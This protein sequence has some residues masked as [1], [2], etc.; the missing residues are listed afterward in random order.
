P[1]RRPL[2]LRRSDARARAAAARCRPAL[3]DRGHRPRGVVDHPPASVTGMPDA[4]EQ[5]DGSAEDRSWLA[6]WRRQVAAL[7][8]EVRALSASDPAVAHRHWRKVR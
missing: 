5:G 4:W 3:A 8:A 6:D 1:R 2:V 7:Y